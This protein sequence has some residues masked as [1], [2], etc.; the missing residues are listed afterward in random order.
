MNVEELKLKV[1]ESIDALTYHGKSAHASAMPHEGL[2]ALDEL[3]TAYQTVAQ[4][5]QH[6]RPTK[7]IHGIFTKADLAPNI[8]PD[9][10]TGSERGDKACIDGAKSLAMTA[11]DYL[12][13]ESLRQ[14][15]ADEFKLTADVS[16]C[17]VMPAY[18]PQGDTNIGGA[19][20]QTSC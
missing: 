1:C 8:V 19:V 6:I 12:T 20:K 9:R 11:L 15:A 16:T 5:R 18:D 3:V 10:V 4:L 7:R 13:D 14:L 2:N 17:A